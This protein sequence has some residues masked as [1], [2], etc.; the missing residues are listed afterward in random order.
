MSATIDQ[1][2]DTGQVANLELLD[3]MADGHDSTDDFVARHRGIKGV[4]PLI[5]HGMQVGM[6]NPTIKNLNLHIVWTRLPTLNLQGSQGN[7][8]ALR[9]KGF[10]SIHIRKTP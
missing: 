6:A 8:G 9:A 2:A 5:S 3:L 10:N 7:V 1:T 4:L